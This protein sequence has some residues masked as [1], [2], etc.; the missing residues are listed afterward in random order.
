M[1]TYLKYPIWTLRQLIVAPRQAL[2]NTVIV[3]AAFLRTLLVGRRAVRVLQAHYAG[4]GCRHPRHAWSEAARGRYIWR[5]AH[6]FWARWILQFAGAKLSTVGYEHLDWRQPYVVVANH[7][8]TVDI[9][10]LVA[11]M[12]NGR[13]V[14][15]KEVL[16]YPVLGGAAR[17]GGQIVIDRGDHVQSMAA[18]RAGMSQWPRCHIIFFPEGTRT[19]SGELGSF[20]FGAFAVAQEMRLA[21]VPVA[22]SGAFQALRKGSLLRLRRHPE[23]RVEFG[24][25]ISAGA[26]TK[27]EIPRLAAAVRARI[28]D[29]LARHT[30]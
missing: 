6:R 28:A 15:K 4:G 3:L 26:A 24:A 21:I 13:F 25:P 10:A 27:E 14:A 23:I 16:H 11:I 7:Q 22:I 18:I 17:Y 9:L 5:V 8:S 12:D 29:M 2:R 19:R 30:Y 1:F 20:R